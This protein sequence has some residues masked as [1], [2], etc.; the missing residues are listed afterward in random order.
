MNR[1]LFGLLVIVFCIALVVVMASCE[2]PSSRRLG[3]V[4]V[5]SKPRLQTLLVITSVEIKD[6]RPALSLFKVKIVGSPGT[7]LYSDS[8]LFTRG[9]TIVQLRGFYNAFV[10]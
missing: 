7:Y 10:Q 5:T 3:D 1:N 8:F 9:D 2:S 6:F 4:I